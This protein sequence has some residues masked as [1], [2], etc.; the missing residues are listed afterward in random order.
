MFEFARIQNLKQKNNAVSEFVLCVEWKLVK[1]HWIVLVL[2]IK[3]SQGK[4]KFP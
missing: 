3:L 2:Y 4:Q 1:G